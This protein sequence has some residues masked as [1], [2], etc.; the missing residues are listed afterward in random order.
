MHCSYFGWRYQIREAQNV[1]TEYALWGRIVRWLGADIGPLGGRFMRE[2]L[3]CKVLF[4]SLDLDESWL[5][6][7]L[8]GHSTEARLGQFA[9][10]ELFF[11]AGLC[12]W[13]VQLP[14]IAAAKTH[15]QNG[16]IATRI[17]LF[18][19]VDRLVSLSCRPAARS[20][21]SLCP[22]LEFA[23]ELASGLALFNRPSTDC[24]P[25]C[26]V[27]YFMTFCDS[28]WD[29]ISPVLPIEACCPN[30]TPT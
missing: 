25:G 18:L 19:P 12:L 3:A 4:S 8:Q 15:S 26:Q 30:P 20:T 24:S 5:V 21:S 13:H 11:P 28:G 17:R 16:Q 7:V 10:L 23:Q 9:S 2:I 29:T 27:S 22:R 1:R 6:K 14:K